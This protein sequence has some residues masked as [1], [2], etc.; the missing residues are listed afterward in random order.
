MRTLVHA[1]ERDAHRTADRLRTETGRTVLWLLCA[2]YLTVAGWAW[3]AVGVVVAAV[4][5]LIVMLI[6]RLGVS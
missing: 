6:A 5:L 1:L 3:D 4:V 2:A